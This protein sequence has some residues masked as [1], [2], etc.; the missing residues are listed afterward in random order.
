VAERE[1]MEDNRIEIKQVSDKEFLVGQS[2]LFIDSDGIV[3]MVIVGVIDGNMSGMM[4]EVFFK[5]TKTIAGEKRLLVDIND[6]RSVSREARKNAQ[7]TFEVDKKIKL[8]AFGLHPV[9]RMIATFVIGAL[10]KKYMRFFK[11][12]EDALAWLKED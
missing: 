6:T 11:N 12:R 3:N 9:A 1:I 5:L 7:Q 2:R 10:Q 4:T 8:A